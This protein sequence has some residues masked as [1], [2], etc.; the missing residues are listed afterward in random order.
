MGNTLRL[1][2]PKKLMLMPGILIVMYVFGTL[3]FVFL[4]S[5]MQYIPG[6]AGFEQYGLVY[7]VLCLLGVMCNFAIL[8]GHRW[9]VF[10]QITVWIANLVVNLFL[11]RQFEP[12]FGLSLLFIG[13]WIFNIYQNR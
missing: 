13:L 2:A 7:S 6:F 10:G 8:R 9:G 5:G 1:T 11:Q 12:Y 3:G 4:W